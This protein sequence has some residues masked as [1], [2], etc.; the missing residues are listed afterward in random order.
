MDCI[1]H[2]I[3]KSQTRLSDFH[4][5]C[6]FFF[7]QYVLCFDKLGNLESENLILELQFSHLP[8]ASYSKPELKPFSFSFI[9][10]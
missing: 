2:R 10:F 5:H 1:V 8:V 4:F 9:G 6:F 3:T 7:F